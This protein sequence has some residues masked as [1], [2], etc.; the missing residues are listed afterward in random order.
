MVDPKKLVVVWD[1]PAY[2]SLQ[3]AIKYIKEDSVANAEGVQQ[4]ILKM[5]REL[6]DHPEKHPRDKFKKNN[7]GNYR[8]F[9]K[10]SFRIAYKITEREIIILRVRHVK[11][12]PLEYK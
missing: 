2:S 4:G 10:Y 5:I 8:A 6:Q 12:E 1:K 7:P 9:E 3:T 11:Q